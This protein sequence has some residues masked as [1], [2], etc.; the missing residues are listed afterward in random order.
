M[1]K[2]VDFRENYGRYSEMK[3]KKEKLRR[4]LNFKKILDNS[5]KK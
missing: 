4:I 5:D 2:I 3:E 1:Y